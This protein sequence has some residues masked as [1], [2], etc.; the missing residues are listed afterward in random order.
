MPLHYVSTLSAVQAQALQ[1]RQAQAHPGQ[2]TTVPA[3]AA[4][5]G[6]RLPEIGDPSP[7]APPGRG[8]SRSKWVA[9]RYLARARRAGATVTVLRLGEV[10]P[11]QEY[12]HPNPRALTHLLLAGIHRL[13]AAPDAAIRS[14][15]T[16]VD[17]AAAR[18]VAAV[19]DRAAWNRVLHVFHPQSVDFAEALSM[20]GA[21][22]TRTSCAAFLTRLRDAAQQTGDTGLAGLAALIPAPAGSREPALRA[23]LAS[24]LTDNASLYRKDECLRLEE[25]CQLSEPDLRG[26]IAAYLAYLDAAAAP[27][28]TGPGQAGAAQA[29]PAPPV[30]VPPTRTADHLTGRP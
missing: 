5:G 25:R 3:P 23:A 14:D 16:P 13:G 26:P 2:A 19:L 20:A 6:G 11:S 8:Y 7:A 10:L 18:V 22:V 24:L 21:P 27:A 28:G 12:V 1:A 30:V 15:Y 4:P 9:E 17:Y 29:S